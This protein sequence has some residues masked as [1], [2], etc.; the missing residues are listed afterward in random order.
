M[1]GL[2]EIQ[3]EHAKHWVRTLPEKVGSADSQE[4]G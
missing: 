3:I 4:S 2:A 1:V